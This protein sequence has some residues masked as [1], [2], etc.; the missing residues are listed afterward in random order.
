[1]NT[2]KLNSAPSNKPARYVVIHG[3]PHEDGYASYSTKL[4]GIKGLPSSYSMAIHTAARFG[5]EVFAGYETSEG[6]ALL[7]VKSYRRNYA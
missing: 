2:N 1:M 6:P 4:D 7:P 5:G 3:E